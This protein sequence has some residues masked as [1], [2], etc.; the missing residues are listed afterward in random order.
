MSKKEKLKKRFASKPKDFSFDELTTLLI[1]LGYQIS[2][3]GKTS[4]SRVQ[5][6][7]KTTSHVIICHKPHPSNIVKSYVISQIV[8]EL[9]KENLL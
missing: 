7:N 6:I 3:K 8:D 9:K 4:G 5:F 2:N 1:I